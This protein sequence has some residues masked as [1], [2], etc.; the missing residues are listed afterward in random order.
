MT[1]EPFPGPRHWLANCIKGE[2]KN[3]KPLPILAN[4]L[5]ALRN[6]PAVRDALAYDAMA[7]AAMLMHEIG[8]PLNGNLLEPRPLMDQDFTDFQE[9]MQG[10][11]LKRIAH[12]VVRHA[13]EA[14]AR[15]NTYHP[16]L[17]Y[18]ESLRW[19]GAPRLNVWLT[20]KLGA[21]LNPYTQA[22]GQMFL[23][24]MVAR[25]FEPGCKADHM[26]VLEGPQGEL[27]SSACAELAGGWFSDHLPDITHKDAL[28]HLR[29]KWLIEIAE[30]HAFNKA[31]TSL[32]KSFIS[33]RIERY[34]PSHG[35]LEVHEPRQCV[36]I[37]TTNKDT[38]LRHET[39]GRRFWPVKTGRIDLDGL[40]WDRDQL[41]AEAV[42]LYR[43]GVQWW[44]DKA[45]EREHIQP[46]QEAR[47]EGDAWEEP[48]REFLQTVTSTTISQVAKSALD[49][50]TDRLGT[51][52][53]RRIA[54]VLTTIGWMH[55]K[56]EPGTGARLWIKGGN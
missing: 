16:I 13:V 42:T 24:S 18:L 1:V 29:G 31:E 38:Y 23:I 41:F 46:E 53:Q 45:F 9:W 51:A 19:D 43:A 20:T 28:Q 14:H 50:K 54:A 34:R 5:I 48:I 33:R 32:L 27:K 44:P 47:Y 8:H 21:D 39:G 17:N 6:D 25:I 10:A 56:R 36:F 49:F 12:E 11:G 15:R 37:G 22:V 40:A 4:V 7:C 2:G 26:L 35:R 3:P 30:M 52:D 55:G